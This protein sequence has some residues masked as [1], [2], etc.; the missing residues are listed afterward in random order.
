MSQEYFGKPADRA[1]QAARRVEAIR[2][3]LTDS[4]NDVVDPDALLHQM[5]EH[6]G[7]GYDPQ[8]GALINA[9]SVYDAIRTAQPQAFKSLAVGQ[10]G[11]P[12]YKRE[13]AENER[14]LAQ[15]ERFWPKTGRQSAEDAKVLNQLALTDRPAYVRLRAKARVMGRV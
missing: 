3:F 10:D 8:T 15:I 14:D 12:A 7:V 1:T 6:N 13:L 5:V 11:S 9:A 2:Q 4:G